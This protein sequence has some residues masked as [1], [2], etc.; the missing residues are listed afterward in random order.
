[1]LN[2]QWQQADKQ[3]VDNFLFMAKSCDQTFPD[4]NRSANFNRYIQQKL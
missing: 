1:V 2:L 4:S 3:A